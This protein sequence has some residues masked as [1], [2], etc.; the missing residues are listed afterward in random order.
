MLPM[1][2]LFE[3]SPAF[4]LCEPERSKISDIDSFVRRERFETCDIWL[5]RS[6]G[7]LRPNFLSWKVFAL[8]YDYFSIAEWLGVPAANG[9]L[10]CDY[11]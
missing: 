5:F 10:I 1:V 2:D 4:D 9:T 7:T 8:S 11:E 6:E 3:I